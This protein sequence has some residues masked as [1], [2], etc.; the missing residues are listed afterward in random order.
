M[1]IS[2]RHYLFAEDGLQ[3]L[4]RRLVEGL[5]QGKDAMPQYAGTKQKSAEVILESENGKPVRIAQANGSFLTFDKNGQVH[6]DLALGGMQA[7][8]TFDAL[9]RAQRQSASK[10]VDLSP[11][12]NR[13]KWERDY[14]WKLSKADLDLIADDIWN[15]KR[16]A[17]PKVQQAKGVAPKPVPLTYE[18]KEAIEEFSR[19]L[20]GIDIKL[21]F[22]SEPA[23]KGIAYE[24]RRRATREENG[25]LWLGLA[26][27]AD[28]RREIKARHRTGSGGIW[29]AVIDVI[30][31]DHTRVGNSV[32]SKEEKCASKKEA[33]E[34]ARRLLVQHAEYFSADHSLE[35][36]VICD[37]EWSGD[38]PGDN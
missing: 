3:R 35:V 28:H 8:E 19:Q 18:A 29:Y 34:V 14:R 27:G 32:F 6:Q 37:L 17:T 25:K 10:V 5:V 24:A 20:N 7:M 31:W 12:L 26:D 9:Q 13:E 4:S 1:S 30:A 36:K 11:K 33:E 16:A 38:D 2:V 15:R 21:E 22:L 23:L